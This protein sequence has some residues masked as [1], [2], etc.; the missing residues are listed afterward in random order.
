MAIEFPQNKEIS[1]GGKDKGRKRVGFAIRRRKVN[2]GSINIKE[3]EREEV[4]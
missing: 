1:G 3:R 4:V 2:R